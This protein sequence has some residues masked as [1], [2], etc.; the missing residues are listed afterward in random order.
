M[1]PELAAD[2]EDLANAVLQPTPR[3]ESVSVSV[4]VPESVEELEPEKTADLVYSHGDDGAHMPNSVTE[5]DLSPPEAEGRSR[6]KK[7]KEEAKEEKGRSKGRGRKK[8]GKKRGK[9][10]RK[11][12]REKRRERR[13]R[14]RK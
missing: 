1:T 5:H 9:K 8:R 4:R 11:K 2:L 3:V 13:R 12:R 6:Q 14:K 7:Q 10:R